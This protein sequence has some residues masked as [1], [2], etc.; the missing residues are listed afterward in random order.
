MILISIKNSDALQFQHSKILNIW[1]KQPNKNLINQF[2]PK[3]QYIYIENRCLVLSEM[4][5]KGLNY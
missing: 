4:V 2:N 1:L 5:L 3:L